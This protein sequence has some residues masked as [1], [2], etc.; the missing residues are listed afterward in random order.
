MHRLCVTIACITIIAWEKDCLNPTNTEGN[1][2]WVGL[3]LNTKV[4]DLSGRER[5]ARVR[6]RKGQSRGVQACA[7]S[8]LSP[9]IHAMRP[10]LLLAVAVAGLGAALFRAPF[11]RKKRQI[12][13]LD[14]PGY[15]VGRYGELV[16]ENG[17]LI[18]GLLVFS[19]RLGA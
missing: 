17:S 1:K 12:D 3:G 6:F 4:S 7:G 2:K 5:R 19:F 18:H 8:V 11:E 16:I 10:S 14:D 9:G 13:Q 15:G